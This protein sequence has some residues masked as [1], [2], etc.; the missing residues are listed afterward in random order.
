MSTGWKARPFSQAEFARRQ[1]VDFL[2]IRL[3]MASPED[4]ILS[5]LER[6]QKAG[7]ERQLRDVRGILAAKPDALDLACIERWVEDLGLTEEW[8]RVRAG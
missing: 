1:Q 4:V 7:S 2:G 6:A 5:K 3:W 8:N